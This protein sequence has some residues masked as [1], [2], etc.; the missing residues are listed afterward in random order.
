MRARKNQ[1]YCE[2]RKDSYSHGAASTSYS[3]GFATWY[4]AEIVGYNIREAGAN[5]F[6][7]R[8][9]THRSNHQCRTTSQTQEVD[10]H[11]LKL[12]GATSTNCDGHQ[13]AWKEKGRLIWSESETT[14][15]WVLLRYP[16]LPRCSLSMLFLANIR[17]STLNQKIPGF[18]QTVKLSTVC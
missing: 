18:F 9:E 4:N 16:P 14:G 1:I 13:I 10:G 8:S 12:F 15:H 17:Y 5:F 3:Y 2:K 7:T 6:H 11:R